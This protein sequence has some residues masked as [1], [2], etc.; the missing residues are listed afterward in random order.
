MLHH[1]FCIFEGTLD[2]KL[3]KKMSDFFIEFSRD[4]YF[5]LSTKDYDSGAEK[6][7]F[8]L[9][10]NDADDYDPKSENFLISYF[11]KRNYSQIPCKPEPCRY[12]TKRFPRAIGLVDHYLQDHTLKLYDFFK[13]IASNDEIDDRMVCMASLLLLTW[14]DRDQERKNTSPKFSLE[15]TGQPEERRKMNP[16]NLEDPSSSRNQP[17]AQASNACQ[18]ENTGKAVVDSTSGSKSSNHCSNC[19]MISADYSPA[20]KKQAIDTASMIETSKRPE[21]IISPSEKNIS[22]AS[23][24]R[25]S[26][27]SGPRVLKNWQKPLSKR[28]QHAKNLANHPRQILLCDVPKK[29]SKR[30]GHLFEKARGSFDYISNMYNRKDV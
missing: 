12:V 13:H 8:C 1:F 18:P 15:N 3:R 5:A 17:K 24:T 7:F 16:G 25:A 27:L 6:N 20:T 29:T 9:C 28:D 2:N 10:F 22:E 21:K 4:Y 30:K 26:A 19:G 23:S 11:I 14:R